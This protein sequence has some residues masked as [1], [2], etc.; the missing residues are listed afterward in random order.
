MARRLLLQQIAGLVAAACTP[1]WAGHGPTQRVDD[2]VA[3]WQL[4]SLALTNDRRQA[5]TEKLLKGHWNFVLFGSASRCT[6]QC[7]E[8]LNALVG[9]HKRIAAS[10]KIKTT[11]L[12]FVALDAA[13]DTPERLRAYLAGYDAPIIGYS[14]TPQMLKRLRDELQIAPDSRSSLWLIGP[15]LVVR[16]EFLPPYDAKLLASFYMR[17]RSRG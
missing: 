4:D 5:V 15:N 8:A 16:A 6:E 12:L 17:M 7:V 13:A 11:Q 1:A 9:M 2:H 3:G 14:G 10:D